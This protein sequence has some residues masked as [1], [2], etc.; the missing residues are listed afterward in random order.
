MKLWRKGIPFA[1]TTLVACLSCAAWASPPSS[2]AYVTDH[3]NVWVQ[4]Q[5]GDKVGTVNMIMCII[6]SMRADAMVN[7]G[8]YVALIDE[9]KCQGR[10]DTSKSTSNNAG[11]SNATNYM[12]SVINA[13]QASTDDPLIIK[14]WLHE[15][16]EDNGSTQKSMIYAYVS[17]SAAP[18]ATNPNGLFQMYFCGEDTASPGTCVFKGSLQSDGNGLSFFNHEVRNGVQD[19]KLTL[20][21]NPAQDSGLGRVSGVDMQG[22]TAVPFNYAFAY[23]A[24]NFLRTDGSSPVCF[25]RDHTHGDISTWSY[26]T[27]NSD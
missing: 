10:G 4:D 2:G 19:T 3:A 12:F 16:Q 1:V 7:H 17:A 20:Q 24:S 21:N 9:N 27:Y 18:S 6:S 14:A 11:A 8:P 5:V 22:N 23:N 13:T 26:G 15:E 25:D